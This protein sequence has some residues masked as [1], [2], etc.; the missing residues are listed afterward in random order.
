[1]KNMRKIFDFRCKANHITEH[2]VDTESTVDCPECG[3]K[4]VKI[5]SPVNFTLDPVSGD[6]PGATMKWARDHER[7]SHNE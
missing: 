6:F 3:E 1:M 4:A 2:L 5:I 7:A